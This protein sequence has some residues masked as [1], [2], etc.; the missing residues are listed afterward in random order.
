MSAL[1][2]RCDTSG[3]VR[4]VLRDGVGL[5]SDAVGRALGALLDPSSLRGALQLIEGARHGQ[6]TIGRE[7][8]VATPAR[9]RILVSA[10]AADERGVLLLAA[11]SHRELRE[12][13]GSFAEQE[14]PAVQVI[15]RALAELG[16]DSEVSERAF[17]ELSRVYNEL[18]NLER[19]LAIR[20]ARIERL[21][22]EKDR[23]LG[24][25]AHDL[26][27]PLGSVLMSASFL[28]LE[29]ADRLTPT[30]LD[31][32]DRI[33]RAGASMGRLVDDLLDT[34][35]V[36][37]GSPSLKFAPVALAELLREACAVHA[38]L[39]RVR[40]IEV[41][42]EIDSEL[43]M[44]EADAERLRQVVANLLSNAVDHTPTGGE[45]VVIARALDES[46]EVSVLDGGSGIEPDVLPRLFV[47]FSGGHGARH[48]GRSVGLGLAICK[49]LVVGHGGSIRAENRASGG[50]A[51]HVT[52]PRSRG[53]PD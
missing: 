16:S 5:P 27:G 46:I 33:E 20:S 51:F 49:A 3:V 32:L 15:A 44:L 41:R 6:V 30:E 1:A 19:E 39:A 14:G 40:A 31:V 53:R 11:A 45:V 47:P 50:A 12:L 22:Q 23:V 48:A 36:Q 2:L 21:S 17:D 52:L 7:L 43:P 42:L 34:A 26:R 10:C 28:K 4:A 37:N 25:A 13:C 9:A 29:A 8:L 24:M 35:S 18:A 38:A